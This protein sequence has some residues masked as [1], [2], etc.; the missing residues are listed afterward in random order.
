MKQIKKKTITVI[1]IIKIMSVNRDKHVSVEWFA[2]KPD[3]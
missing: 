2:L 1:S 3:W